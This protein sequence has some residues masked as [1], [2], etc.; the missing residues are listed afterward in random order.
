V[1]WTWPTPPRRW[2]TSRKN[3][4]VGSAVVRGRTAVAPHDVTD[5]RGRSFGCRQRSCAFHQDFA[6]SVWFGGASTLE[7]SPPDGTFQYR[8]AACVGQPGLGFDRSGRSMCISTGRKRQTTPGPVGPALRAP[9]LILPPSVPMTLLLPRVSGPGAPLQAASRR[10]P[11]AIRAR[12][13]PR[14]RGPRPLFIRSGAGK[15]R[16]AAG[17]AA[18]GLSARAAARGRRTRR[19]QPR[20]ATVAARARTSRPR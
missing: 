2:F 17:G 5:P 18:L 13:V 19:R 4:P 3:D 1:P 11:H 12:P 8:E 16:A 15:L 14:H 20:R 6:P 10:L 9:V 7:L